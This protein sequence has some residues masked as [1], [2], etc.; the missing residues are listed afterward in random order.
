MKSMLSADLC[1]AII[2]MTLFHGLAKRS[3]AELLAISSATVGRVRKYWRQHHDVRAAGRRHEVLAR[4][5]DEMVM[6]V[7]TA[8]TVNADLYLDEIQDT[9]LRLTGSHISFS[10]IS[11]ILHQVLGYSRKK[12]VTFAK[13]ARLDK[14][15][16]FRRE[17]RDILVDNSQLVF[18]DESRADE[19]TSARMWGWGPVNRR[20]NALTKFVRGSSFSVVAG[21][22]LDGVIAASVYP[23]GLTGLTF[24]EWVRDQLVPELG[25]YPGPRSIVVLDNAKIHWTDHAAWTEL[26]DF[27]GAK[28]VFLP[29]YSPDYNP[30]EL[31]FN[32]G[33][34]YLKHMGDMNP[35]VALHLA[36][37]MVSR[38]VDHAAAI[39]YCGYY[40]DLGGELVAFFEPHDLRMRDDASD[41]GENY[42]ENDESGD[43]EAVDLGLAHGNEDLL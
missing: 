11:R 27:V 39:E 16:E 8:I 3:V 28:V 2:H 1:W 10:K 21:Y 19:R 26:V 41:D 35:D 30:I 33:K 15:L 37:D 14:R 20:V 32:T 25:A 9:V 6:A 12:M 40:Y 24:Y 42:G 29:P 4:I 7:Q 31:V 18:V 23:G 34:S 38:Y 22:C 36:M 5:P 17:L 13:E 43:E